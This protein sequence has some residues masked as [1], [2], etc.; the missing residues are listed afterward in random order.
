M[1][2]AQSCPSLRS[3]PASPDWWPAAPRS[4][5][6]QPGVRL[7]SPDQGSP[8]W[9]TTATANVSLCVSIPAN[10]GTS[11]ML[12]DV[13][14]CRLC[15]CICGE[16]PTPLSGV[17]ASLNVAGR[18]PLSEPNRRPAAAK[19]GPFRRRHGPRPQVE[20]RPDNHRCTGCVADGVLRYPS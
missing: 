6:T 15:A 1:S 8:T 2:P 4:G 3:R 18:Q 17:T 12:I 14:A 13:T 10:T 9:S 20:A 11:R 16:D 7:F 19:V 5:R